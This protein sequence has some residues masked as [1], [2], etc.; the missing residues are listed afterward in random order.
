M[1]SQVAGAADKGVF[2]SESLH[3]ETRPP[4]AVEGERGSGVSLLIPEGGA[5]F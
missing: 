5:V 4:P 3:P 2:V 1:I